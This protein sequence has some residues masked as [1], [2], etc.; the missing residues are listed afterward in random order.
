MQVRGHGEAFDRPGGEISQQGLVVAL[1]SAT[2]TAELMQKLAK[3]TS[4]SAPGR[5]EL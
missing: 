3:S 4:S 1:E 5:A 2:R